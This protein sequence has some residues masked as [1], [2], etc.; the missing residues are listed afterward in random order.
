MII[1]EHILLLLVCAAVLGAGCTDMGGNGA[2]NGTGSDQTPSESEDLESEQNDSRDE[3]DSPF[4]SSDESDTSNEDDSGESTRDSDTETSDESSSDTETPDA[5]DEDTAADHRDLTVTVTDASGE[6]ATGVDVTST[7]DASNES[8][9]LTT[10][11]DGTVVFSVL[12]GEFS[13]SAGD[14]FETV[15]V[16]GNTDATLETDIQPEEDSD[17][18]SSEQEQDE[19]TEEQTDE[20]ESSGEGS[21]NEN[22]SNEEDETESPPEENGNDGDTEEPTP[23][24]DPDPNPGG[25]EENNSEGNETP[26]GD[27]EENDSEENTTES[28]AD[29][30]PNTTMTVTLVDQ[31]GEPVQGEVEMY[32]VGYAQTVTATTDSNGV[33][34]FEDLPDQSEGGGPTYQAELGANTDGYLVSEGFSDFTTVIEGG[35]DNTHTLDVIEEP[36]VHDVSMTVVDAD[37][38]ASIEDATIQASGGRYPAGGDKVFE[39]TTNADGTYSTTAAEGQYEIQ[40]RHGAY[41]SDSQTVDIDGDT[42]IEFKLETHH[43]TPQPNESNESG[44]PNATAA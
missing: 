42:E 3:S 32:L 40:A 25:N 15:T 6:P 37:T 17:A 11:G 5:S 2:D 43:L 8:R 10:D 12:N 13:I 38:G 4:G 18:S 9:T 39:G 44:G 22:N 19:Q 27:G 26:P 30:E 16:D 41:S 34:T 24:P 1:R 35:E 28:P 14:S 36:S 31:N 29:P 21:T 7:H 33:A 20:T 23:A